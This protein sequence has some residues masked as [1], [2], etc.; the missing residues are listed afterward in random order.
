MRKKNWLIALACIAACV[1]GWNLPVS[2]SSITQLAYSIVENAG[3]ALTQR[4]TLNFAGSVTCADNASKLRTD[5]TANTVGG[6]NVQTSSY[7]IQASDSGQTV[8]MN[9]SS[10]CA[11]TLFG[12]PTGGFSVTVIS[13]GSTLATINMNSLNYNGQASPP[14]LL[15]FQAVT[16]SWSTTLSSYVGGAPP[17]QGTNMTLN[18]AATG[19]TYSSSGGGGGGGST[20]FGTFSALP[21][22]TAGA[23]YIQTDGPYYFVGAGSPTATWTAFLPGH[24]EVSN[25]MPSFAWANQGASTVTTTHGGEIMSITS[26][27]SDSFRTRIVAVPSTPWSIQI[28][29]KQ[30]PW[31]PSFS[32]SGIIM[33]D[34]VGGRA[35]VCGSGSS[36]GDIDLQTQHLTSLTSVN[37]N[38]FSIDY[39]H[40]QSGDVVWIKMFNDGTTLHCYE[41]STS[42]VTWNQ[43]FSESATTWVTTPT[44]VGYTYDINNDS[45]S[46][47]M[48]VLH[49]L[50][51][52]N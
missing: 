21:P 26:G 18:A 24:A 1:I 32:G 20:T 2:A 27:G 12:S 52:T 49:W 30:T 35:V 48:W 22:A 10:A 46:G 23:A 44:S 17:V 16:F 19:L 14:V 51:G 31:S 45:L 8:V 29:Y 50:Q 9:C 39:S 43:Y 4:N 40:G 38:P 36:G 15:S 28:A 34:S 42:G 7:V 37:S 3:S 5:C 25:T 11:A 33:Y 6:T 13:V 41:S 47:T